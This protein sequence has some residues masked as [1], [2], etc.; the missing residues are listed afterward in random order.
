M[1]IT[2]EIS[3]VEIIPK[4]VSTGVRYYNGIDR[5]GLWRGMGQITLS[6]ESVGIYVY[7]DTG[8]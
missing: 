1:E 8:G 6:Q 3:R 2:R 4:A 7:D 5:H